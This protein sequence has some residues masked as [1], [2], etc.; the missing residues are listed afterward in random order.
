MF[1]CIRRI[2]HLRWNSRA[3]ESNGKDSRPGCNKV[4]YQCGNALL[5][6]LVGAVGGKEY[7]QPLISIMV[8]HFSPADRAYARVLCIYE[9]NAD[10][11]GRKF[12]PGS[13]YCPAS[14]A[15]AFIPE[16]RTHKRA[17]RSETATKVVAW[18]WII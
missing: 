10:N 9:L 8:R 11:L 1:N 4:V 18:R 13:L 17:S 2:Q 15:P 6:L 3:R 12:R 16:V 7:I 14:P 5:V